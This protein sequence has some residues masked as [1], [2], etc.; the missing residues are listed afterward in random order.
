MVLNAITGFNAPSSGQ[1]LINGTNITGVAPFRH[2]MLTVGPGAFVPRP[3]TELLVDA[4]LAHLRGL[5]APLVIDLCAGAGALGLAVA[6]EVPGA[7]VVLVERSPAALRYLA[8]NAASIDAE[9]VRVVAGDL[10]DAE[11]L[12][13]LHGRADA[14]LSNPPYVP[15]A[16]AVAAEVH[17][18]PPE[19][20]FAGDDGL[21]LLPTVINRAAQLLVVG[22]VLA[23]EH[24]DTHE[25]AVP[26]LLTADGRFDEVRDHRDL[27]GRPRFATA[28]RCEE[29]S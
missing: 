29:H 22:G 2:L 11:L 1:V 28:R 12:R 20:V 14:V 25:R 10:R 19:A 26:A 27:G 3:E 8:E 6:N 15:S 7:Q 21:G 4:V 5:D 9:R 23:V 18:D 17:A 24:D 16:V 13:P